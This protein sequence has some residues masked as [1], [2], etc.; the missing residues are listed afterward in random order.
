[1]LKL[2]SKVK[3]IKSDSWIYAKEESD[4]PFIISVALT[5][6][7]NSSESVSLSLKCDHQTSTPEAE[8]SLR[9]TLDHQDN[10]FAE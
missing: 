8:M 10:T 5:N 7:F 9:E 3:K 1:M 4:H 6:F 2:L